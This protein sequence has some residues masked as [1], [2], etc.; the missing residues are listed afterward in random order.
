MNTKRLW[1]GNA[2]TPASF[3]AGADR[4]IRIKRVIRYFT[5]S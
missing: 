5:T 2:T 4:D 3:P 1:D